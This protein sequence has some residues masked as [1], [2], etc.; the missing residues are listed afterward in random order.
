M[1]FV[2]VYGSVIVGTYAA[3]KITGALPALSCAYDQMNGALLRAGADPAHQ[4]HHRIGEAHGAGT[5]TD[6]QMMLPL[7]MSSLPSSPSSSSSA[8]PS[9][10][11]SARWARLQEWIGKIG[12]RF[13]IGL[14][15]FEK[16]DLGEKSSACARSSGCCCSAWCSCCRC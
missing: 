12:R 5:A 13:G 7:L 4:V 9:A 10:A 3:D 1:L 6:L 16:G 14:R 11:G 2:T 8:R 15:R